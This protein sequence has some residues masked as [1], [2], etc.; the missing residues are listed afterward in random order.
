MIAIFSLNTLFPEL[1]TNISLKKI[2]LKHAFFFS[3]VLDLLN[4]DF[5][6][7]SVT[8]IACKTKERT[9]PLR[10]YIKSHCV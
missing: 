10:Y 4:P 8:F 7:S 9:N 1:Q 3:R 6:F 2:N 5:S